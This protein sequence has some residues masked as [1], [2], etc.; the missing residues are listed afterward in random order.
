MTP[1]RV[2]FGPPFAGR[3]SFDVLI[4]V[5]GGLLLGLVLVVRPPLALAAGLGVVGLTGLMLLARWRTVNPILLIVPAV[6]IGGMK[7]RYRLASESLEG[8]V[9][10]NILFELGVYV[11]VFALVV[12]VAYTRR[13]GLLRPTRA[14]GWL[15][16][17]AAWAVISTAW[18]V[19]PNFT[20]VRGVQTVILIVAAVTL[21]R[22]VPFERIVAR[23]SGAYV[24]VI[25]LAAVLALT[26]P[27]ARGVRLDWFTGSPRFA[28]FAD[29]P[30]QV[31]VHCGLAA[32]LL[33]CVI[34][35]RPD[36]RRRS[37]KTAGWAWV[38]LLL[39]LGIMAATVSRGP[40]VA[41]LSAAAA[42]VA[43]RYL[44]V[45]ESALVVCGVLGLMLAATLF[46]SPLQALATLQVEEG[47]L[48]QMLL[49][50]R[51]G[52]N[53]LSMGGRFELWSTA[54][55][56]AGE[57]PLLGYGFIASR[58]PLLEQL[59][60]AGH[61][62]NGPLQSLLDLGV[63]GA[64]LLWIPVLVALIRGLRLH[65]DTRGRMLARLFI[66]GC[67]SFLILVSLTDP[68]LAGPPGP[69]LLFGVLAIL[70]AERYASDRMEALRLP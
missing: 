11:A 16:T 40:I 41:V 26:F 17:Y 8:S 44:D 52:A 68:S 28:W 13:I 47:G 37:G 50:E 12:M 66:V 58:G 27:W 36:G 56:L 23:A 25:L 22:A 43:V 1:G 32:V 62:H 54:T 65:P 4:P 48:M 30:I 5:V 42:M 34:L 18:S 69:A 9:D 7:F 53:L 59:A 51:S 21:A 49:R 19:S 64:M 3:F 46:A 15:Y 57:R 10:A 45:R 31:A 35:E 2:T 60:W 70:I 38:A 6:I 55:A 39:V 20:L 24:G 67:L 14:E 63:L 61:A 33:L 29:H